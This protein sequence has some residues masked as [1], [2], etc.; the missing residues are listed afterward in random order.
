MMAFTVSDDHEAQEAAWF[1]QPDYNRR[2]SDIRSHLTSAQV[3]ARDRRVAFVGLDA[4]LEAGG[5]MNRDLFQ[6]EHEG[7]LTDPALLD[8]L[9][10][11]RFEREAEALRAEGW[12]WVEAVPRRTYADRQ[13]YGR[14]HPTAQPL[15]DDQRQRRDE[16]MA[17]YDALL[18]EHDDEPDEEASAQLDSL[19]E[20]IEAIDE[21]ALAW[22][23]EDRA[24]SGVV[25]SIGHGGELE[26]DAGLVRPDDKTGLPSAAQHGEDGPA[27]ERPAGLS[28]ALTESLTAER[29]AA[30]RATMI[31]NS[32]VAV[33][34][35]CHAMALP[36]FYSAYEAETSCVTLRL[37]CRDLRG[38]TEG[39]EASPALTAV[40]TRQA[41]WEQQ[42]PDDSADLFGWLLGQDMPV[43]INL[44]SFCTAQGIDA[45][46]GKHDGAKA[47]RLVHADAVA[48][49]LGL[50][51]TQW[52]SPTKA[53][54]LGKVSKAVILEAVREGVSPEA[55]DNLSAFK[56]DPLIEVAEQRLAGRGWLPALLRSPAAEP[57]A[58]SYEAMAAE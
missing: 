23:D 41:Q 33:A 39:I 35:L 27:R 19:W 14:V 45:V 28:A 5:T 15:S 42:L 20:R 1:D 6:S 56:K 51:M 2:P 18:A 21:I 8:R 30:L 37:Q 54:Y 10:A 32:N 11:E 22:R 43:L 53:S 7:Y 3:E 48:G 36:L 49:A 57:D 31:D 29:T 25:I 40:S 13:G 9:V 4:Y 38:S 12:K 24:I 58:M 17:A 47:G 16:L 52:W 44:L 34:A 46:R 50:D 55:A 26:T